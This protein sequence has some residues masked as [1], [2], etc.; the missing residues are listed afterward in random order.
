MHRAWIAAS[1][2]LNK[3]FNRA[4][5]SPEQL[6]ALEQELLNHSQL[7]LAL[8]DYYAACHPTSVSGGNISHINQIS[9]ESFVEELHLVDPKNPSHVGFFPRLFFEVFTS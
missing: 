3:L 5:L 6:T 1:P 2:H 9:Y 8:F 7:F 4:R